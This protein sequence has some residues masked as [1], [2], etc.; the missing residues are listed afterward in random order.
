MAEQRT[1]ML[2]R[3]LPGFVEPNTRSDTEGRVAIGSY[4]LLELLPNQGDENDDDYARIAIE[5]LGGDDTWICVRSGT[6]RFAEVVEIQA[7][8]ADLEEL[9]DDPDAVP[10]ETLVTLLPRFRDFH[11][12][13]TN[14]H[15]PFA[16]RGCRLPQAPPRANNCCTFVEALVVG[17][18]QDKYRDLF[19][20]SPA[21]HRQ[22]MVIGDDLFSPVHC[23][24]EAG[25]ASAIGGAASTNS[26][27]P[28]WAVIQGWR[29]D[30][31]GHTFLIVDHHAP[32]D[33]VLTL[34]S[35]RSF[36]LDGVG[37]RKLGNLR[38]HADNGPPPAWWENPSAPTWASIRALY[39]QR[40]MAALKVADRSWSGLPD[41]T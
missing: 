25:I 8:A 14:A 28:P 36:G 31:G 34:E 11:Y 3:N 13:K 29:N 38:D 10:E 16:I 37:F 7:P 17:A 21:Q 15:Y 26:A 35:N 22:M 6:K 18:W 33:R 12:T 39:P 40:E 9:A 1:V 4:R 30:G 5:G 20:W 41:R 2:A 23:L 32:S 27:P 24:V 19:E